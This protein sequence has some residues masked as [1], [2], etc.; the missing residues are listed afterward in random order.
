[1]SVAKTF[2]KNRLLQ[3]LDE[4]P[5]EQAAEVFTFALFLKERFKA[6]STKSH[7]LTVKTLPAAQLRML[8]GIVAWGGDAVEEIERLYEL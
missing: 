3:I 5:E 7:E 6:M 2:D 4:L 1:M 8:V